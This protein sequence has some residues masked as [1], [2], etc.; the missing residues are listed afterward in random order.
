MENVLV[1]GGAGYKGTLLIE[2]LLKKNYK[3]TILDNFLYEQDH[4][5]PFAQNPNCTVIRSDIRNIKSVGL[6]KYDIIYHLAGISGYPA[7][8]A[9]PHSSHTINVTATKDLVNALSPDQIIVYASTTSMYGKSGEELDET[10]TLN[11]VSLYGM[12][13]LQA[14]EIC[15]DH[16]NCVAFRFATLFGISYRMRCDLLLN[17]FVNRAVQERC[18]VLFDSNSVRTFLHVRDAIAAHLMVTDHADQMVGNIYNVGSND[19]NHSKLDLANMIKSHLPK[20]EIVQSALDDFDR[21][22]FI[23]NFDKFIA[24]GF[25]PTITVEDGIKELIRLYQWYKPY[26]PFNT[27]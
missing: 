27:I 10:A 9:N 17:D 24:L 8:E 6:E 12:T 3:V 14:E 2:G 15:M 11:P 22:N 16:K 18:I 5:L 19:M 20:I 13:K 1:T 4:I 25:K 26:V 21:R 23:I 7:C